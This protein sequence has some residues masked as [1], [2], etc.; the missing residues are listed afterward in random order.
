MMTGKRWTCYSMPIVAPT[1]A[2]VLCLCNEHVI[3]YL[4]CML[5]VD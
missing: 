5:W 1:E 4:A 3:F 2:E